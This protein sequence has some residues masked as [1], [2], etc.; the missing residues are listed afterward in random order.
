MA[1][2]KLTVGAVGD[3]VARLHSDLQRQGLDL[4]SEEVRRRFF[5]PGTR[6]AVL[7]CQQKGGLACNGEVDALT[8][9]VLA[10]APMTASGEVQQSQLARSEA[11]RATLDARAIVTTRPSLLARDDRPR[12]ST[13]TANGSGS[14]TP[15]GERQVTGQILLEHGLPASNVTLRLYQRGFGGAETLLEEK[16]TDATGQY[17]IRYGAQ[18]S[19]N[20][21]I[22]AVSGGR[23]I[24]LS[25]TKFSAAEKE[26]INLVAP[27][28]IQPLAPEFTRLTNDLTPHIGSLAQLATAQE[29]A[30]RQ[31]LTLLNRATGWDAR[32]MVLAAN[33][34]ALAA[35]QTVGLSADVLY[36]LFR[37]GLPTDKQLLARIS[38]ETIGLALTRARDAGIV[39]LSDGQIK[40]ATKQ[41]G[42]FARPARLGMAAPGSTSTYGELLSA[43]PVNEDARAKFASVYFAHRGEP[44]R[45]WQNARAAGLTG[46]QIQALQ[47]QGK[48]AF[49]T[50]NN[51][52][53]TTRL[54]KDLKVTDPAQLV[55]RGLYNAESWK[56]EIKG[57]AGDDDQKLA[58]L[59]PTVYQAEK[60]DAR[61]DQYA[62]DMARKVRLSYPTHVVGHM[63]A[64]DER[65][66]MGLGTARGATATLL[67]NS[68]AQGFR[69]GR[70]PVTSFLESHAGVKAGMSAG[71]V[72][73]A[74][75]EMKTLQR[76]YQ[77]APSHEVIPI[78]M[79]LGLKSAYDVV[80]IPEDKFIAIYGP[81]FPT[82]KDPQLVYRRAKQ[83]TSLTYNLV[84]IATK[85]ASEP[86]VFG[87]SAPADVRA[88]VKNE[89]IKQFPT[90][91]TL[92]G[93]MDYCDCD[94]CRSVLSPAAYFVDL[95][96]FIDTEPEVWGN[97]LAHWVSKYRGE[98][99]TD[100]YM[101]P[102][103]ALRERRPDLPA[104]ELTCENT[105]TAMPYIDIV[106]EILEYYVANGKLDS[107]AAWD[108]EGATTAELLAEPHHVIREAY[109][110][111]RDAHYPLRLPFDLSLET[112]RAFCAYFETSYSQVL[113]TFRRDDELF[114][115]GNRYDRATVFIES[116]G[117][118]PAERAIFTDPDPLATWYELYGFGSVTE[119][120]TVATDADTKQRIDLNSAK[121]MSRRL[122]VTYKE[123]VDIVQTGFVNPKLARLTLLDKMD[124]SIHSVIA[125]RDAQNATF[126]QQNKDLLDKQR[127]DLPV[128]DQKRFDALSQDDWHRLKESQGFEALVTAFGTAFELTPAE[129]EAQLLAIPF[130][131]I[132]VLAD[133]DAGCDFD[134]TAL[135]YASG[136]KADEIA[137]L[138]INLFVRL[139]RRLGWTI[140]ETDRAL[141]TFT[142][143]NAPFEKATL[144]KR[145]LLTALISIAH[146]KA[147]DERV[148]VGKR[149]RLKLVTLWSDM[150][151]TGAR[152]LYAQLFLSR[153]V[154]KTDDVFDHPLGEY[155]SPARLDALGRSHWHRVQ[156]EAVPVAQK[157]DPA[158][159]AA[160]SKITVSYDALQEVQRL[161]Y[162]GPL[163]DADKATLNAL[164]S[165]PVLSPLLDAVQA[166]SR[167]FPLVKG[168]V[169]AI[170]GALGLTADDIQR[171][172]E[173]AG[174]AF[175]TAALSLTTVSQL[176]RYALLAKA[177]KLTISR[178]IAL[179]QL[180]GLDPFKHVHP[181]PLTS[182]A[183][184]YPFTH[185]LRFVEIAE[186]VNASGLAIEDLEY[187]LRHQFDTTGKYRPNKGASLGLLR[188]IAEGV[189]AIRL[190]HA[191]PADPGGMSDDVLRQKLGLALP[192]DVVERF[193]AMMNGTTE[194]TAT[195]T[196]VAALAALQPATFSGES[197]IREV[198]YNATRQEQQLTFRGVLFDPE[199]T[200]LLGRLPASVPPSPHVSSV[201]LGALLDDVQHQ[202]RAYFEK[203]LQKQAPHVQPAAG[204]LDATDFE[205]VFLPAPDSLTEDQQQRRIR[206]KRTRLAQAFLP[207]LQERLIRQFIIQT[208]TADTGGDATAVESLLTDPRLLGEPQ[209]TGEAVP[210]LTVLTAAG[211]RGLLATFFASSDGTGSPL[212]ALV[213]ADAYTGLTDSDGVR[214]MPAAA[215]SAT[216]EGYVEVP[217][218]GAYRFFAALDKQ[219]AAAELM[220]A[221][222]PDAVFWTGTAGVD[223][224]VLGD[225][226]GEYLELKPGIS[227]RLTFRLRN[228]GGGDAR[229]LVQGE[230]LPKDVLSQLV[231]NPLTAVA[232]AERALVLLNKSLQLAQGLGLNEREL[233]YVLT[234]APDFGGV[235]LKTLPTT[236]ADASLAGAQAL[237]A[238]VLR[239]MSY[240]RLKRTIAGDAD[241]VIRIFEA[242]EASNL[243][244]AYATVAALTRRD[245]GTV[246]ATAKA[247]FAAPAFA[248]EQPLE[249][250]WQAL[251]VVER[252][253]VPVQSL[254][255]WTGLAI[256]GATGEQRFGIARNVTEAIKARFDP[257]TWQR[258]AQP[259]FD[260]LRQQKRDALVA[261][262]MH[263]HGFD[264]M[265][266]LYQY[267]LIDPGMEPIVQ[268]SRIR[269]AI[270][271]VQLF[272]QRCLLN[273]EAKVH[274]S[275]ILNASLWEWM[276]RYRVWEANRKIF[277]FP[278]NWLEPEFRDDKTHLFTELEGTLLQGDVSSDLVEDAFLS[279][280]RKLEQLARLD[281]VAMHLQDSD[282]P[283][284]RTL[285]VIG[286]TYSEPYQ[287]FYR[288][289]VHEMWTQWEPVSADIQGDHLAPVVWRDRLYL[290]WVTFTQ[291][292][293]PSP[294]APT[295]T[296]KLIDSTIGTVLNDLKAMTGTVEIEAQLHWSEHL[297]GE[298]TT[299][300]SG[301]FSAP[302]AATVASPF[303]P[304][305]VSIHVSTDPRDG[306]GVYI[307]L[308]APIGQSF[309][310]ASRNSTPHAV[311][312]ADA[313]GGTRPANP[314]S[315]TT[316]S[317]TRYAD[318]TSLG[319]TFT[320]RTSTDP[321]KT[322]TRERLDI[323]Q[324]TRQFTLL[325]CDNDIVLGDPDQASLNAQDPTAV[326]QVIKSGLSEIAS[327]MKPFFYQDDAH[328]LFVEPTVNER[329]IEEW[330]EWV[331]QTPQPSQ[332]ST[333]V[334]W[335]KDIEIQQE[336]P[337]VH[338]APE[339]GESW[340]DPT[341]DSVYKIGTKNDWLV[342]PTTGVLYKGAVIGPS[343]HSGLA[344]QPALAAAGA[345]TKGSTLVPVSAGSDVGAEN[346]VVL[347]QGTT[348]ERVG[349]AH[350]EGG[351]NVVGGAGLSAALSDNP[352]AF[353][354]SGIAARLAAGRIGR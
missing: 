326:A 327:L 270:S 141:Q 160:Q 211:E 200:A 119:A 101:K 100:K 143:S 173:D 57:V 237:F 345:I 243:A 262:V 286:R 220:F 333:S 71:D 76:V 254:A 203:Y 56:L 259:I 94:H 185:T 13:P 307:H 280:L 234:H 107:A 142:P 5:G 261:H 308:G 61:L 190:E 113:E 347:A 163:S 135:R 29:D 231:L 322:P 287:Y 198:R 25:K 294:A 14:G 285:H 40:D 306:G 166:A 344:V 223:N 33:A 332:N 122:G 112:V 289:F 172:L 187:L 179:R 15:G 315:A 96:Q 290:F 177:V 194:Y 84:T 123:L 224:A 68:A 196:E 227:Y 2:E 176:Y 298:W 217:A 238:Q 257:E 248:S 62:A 73:A 277:L 208:L 265:E 256:S 20:I 241:D 180:S 229:L 104:I 302:I 210:L 213:L 162:Q 266:Q 130:D 85:M 178:L 161:A 97:F 34:S 281:I 103:E 121:A 90:M 27:T 155:L 77:V 300:E 24:P 197:A 278:E 339:P 269:L 109:D 150:A 323:L 151:T 138:K 174:S 18:G 118:N 212:A 305:S 171:I 188:N 282:D 105:T 318:T 148:Q 341:P 329:T 209:A 272:V 44:E 226:P 337:W 319:V 267:F 232:R 124:A 146:L 276:K 98:N 114:A 271:S 23:E 346:R 126:Y 137:F 92:F 35:D 31:D 144:N 30:E 325:P 317:A 340:T 38:E 149:G 309:L 32:V 206:E 49:L 297:Q 330:E 291:R 48:L 55:D 230:T 250:L 274:P 28:A 99:Y 17:D 16:A 164:S 106:N 59:I 156:R 183:E 328:T 192:A 331:T 86:P 12:A 131:E 233:R 110:R 236:D 132:L 65:D 240:T 205:L 70:T 348:L 354:R 45:L 60:V 222:L 288:R 251:Q 165:S 115:T 53:V 170:Q 117:L 108:T 8:S 26:E 95:L 304:R 69:L 352:A 296:T 301:G 37:A 342:N 225:K 320:E 43:A 292:A 273:L 39:N 268:T 253:G 279:Y 202:A 247:I 228:L 215:R 275:A 191:V 249:H 136:R 239:L 21:E 111:V 120:T 19:A 52:A 201:L 189:R 181:D 195:Q 321:T 199:K 207:F 182:L 66:E 58:A 88:S 343:G 312:S 83:V 221:H 50:G 64:G 314:Y 82:P 67:K 54:Q 133:T 11:A 145:P 7:R 351:L 349:L 41:F 258:V 158:A 252:F 218:S 91:E 81:Y 89:L 79:K 214:M 4:P 42:T 140:E 193:M 80:A 284:F 127:P 310:L 134:A 334:D 63:V 22:R 260:A 128:A 72:Q 169:L 299:H 245:I 9:E 246:K 87:I 74:T 335:W 350:V 47:L 338:V 216:F 324:E 147:L 353:N 152:P 175:D 283:A 51:E 311:A 10:A 263:Q 255:D 78:L 184:D 153:A 313:P 219:N 125:S 168:H 264:R 1:G 139:W 3:E 46:E 303:K 102:Y 186:Q 159:F 244:D 129:I 295:G 154:L 93:S 75:T 204:F 293:D 235:D 157:L 167:E 336:I 6:E 116:L 36:G 316:V 242:N